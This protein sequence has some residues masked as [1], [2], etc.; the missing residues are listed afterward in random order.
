MSETVGGPIWIES[1]SIDWQARALGAEGKIAEMQ[2]ML[3]A[4]IAGHR[5]HRD[6]SEAALTKL[7][8]LERLE[9]AA[10]EYAAVLA[11]P[12]AIDS[13]LFEA[14]DRLEA[15][16]VAYTAENPE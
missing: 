13:E 2:G 10:R 9:T 7:A 4:A 11:R 14:S 12:S 8:R 5:F 3:D 1:P 15:A 6:R 16:A